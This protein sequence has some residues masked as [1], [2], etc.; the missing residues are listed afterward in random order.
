MALPVGSSCASIE[1]GAT[2]RLPSDHALG[3]KS[4]SREWIL[5]PWILILKGLVAMNSAIKTM[6]LIYFLVFLSLVYV[7]VSTVNQAG[8]KIKRSLDRAI[9][10]GIIYGTIEDDYSK[11]RI[12]LDEA[13]VREGTE[14][15]FRKNLRLDTSLSNEAYK[16]GN[17]VVNVTYHNGSPRVTASYKAD[18]KLVAGHIVGL[19]TYDMEVKRQ[20]PYLSDYK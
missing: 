18:I 3:S 14:D 11:G 7:D 16:N 4:I 1:I 12:R 17:L 6:L 8:M 13:K 10:A 5:V 15:I 20:T 9:D 19:E 2:Y